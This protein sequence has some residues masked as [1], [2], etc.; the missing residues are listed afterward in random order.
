[1]LLFNI[2]LI[3][4]IWFLFQGQTN[5]AIEL[6]EILVESYFFDDDSQSDNKFEISTLFRKLLKLDKKKSHCLGQQQT[7]EDLEPLEK[8]GDKIQNQL[9]CISASYWLVFWTFGHS[10]QQFFFSFSPSDVF[11]GNFVKR[12]Q[13][14]K[15]KH[16][17]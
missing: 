10:E 14:L 12:K 3:G 11:P 2:L 4:L 1:M 15:M 17:F 5:R 16:I 9:L 13:K 8:F 7:P 6:I